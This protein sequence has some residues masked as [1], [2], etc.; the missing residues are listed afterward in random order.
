MTPSPIHPLLLLKYGSNQ[1]KAVASRQERKREGGFQTPQ[2]RERKPCVRAYVSS[3]SVCWPQAHLSLGKAP[4]CSV[5]AFRIQSYPTTTSWPIPPRQPA[6][7]CFIKQDQE[8]KT[9]H[10][11]WAEME[12]S[13]AGK[14]EGFSGWA[15]ENTDQGLVVQSSLA[16]LWLLFWQGDQLDLAG[17]CCPVMG[18]ARASG[19]KARNP[20]LISACFTDAWEAENWHLVMLPSPLS[21]SQICLASPRWCLNG[22]ACYCKSIELCRAAEKHLPRCAAQ[23]CLVLIKCS[24]C[25]QSQGMWLCRL[26]RFLRLNPQ[27]LPGD[28]EG[29]L[30][31]RFYS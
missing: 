18:V 5:L 12:N 16:G 14:K 2:P 8:S 30:T 24:L 9:G 17:G 22:Q 31:K 23:F 26:A 19:D 7:D 29:R 11:S 4:L 28:C 21:C 20:E 1:E 25:S 15:V 13:C 6:H 27:C 10:V 3:L